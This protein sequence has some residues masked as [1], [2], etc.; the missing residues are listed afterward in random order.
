MDKAFRLAGVR[1][2]QRCVSVVVVL[3]AV[4][5][6]CFPVQAAI[7]L[8]RIFLP[9]SPV[10]WPT[11]TM[12]SSVRARRQPA[13]GFPQGEDFPVVAVVTA[14]VRPADVEIVYKSRSTDYWTTDRLV[15]DAA[16]LARATTFQAVSEP[17]TFFLRG[18]DDRTDTITLDVIERPR[19]RKIVAWYTYPEYAGL[20]NRRIE[21]GQLRGLEG[22]EV[23]IDF[24]TSGAIQSAFFVAD[25][26]EEPL[27]LTTST[28]FSKTLLLRRDGQYAIKLIDPQGFRE[29]KPERYD[30]QVTPDQP[31]EIRLLAPGRDLVA[32]PQASLKFAFEAKD[33]FGLARVAFYY[34]LQRGGKAEVLSDEITGPIPQ[35]GKESRAEFTWDLATLGLKNNVDLEYWVAAADCNPTGRGV[36]E[37][38]RFKI[39]L[40]TPTDFHNQILY[41]AKKV[42]TEAR[43]PIASRRRPT[44]SATIGSRLATL[45]DGEAHSDLWNQMVEAQETAGRANEAVKR[46]MDELKEHL[47]RNRMQDALME[48]RLVAIEDLRA[49]FTEQMVLARDPLNAA[50]PK[51]SAAAQ[52][53]RLVPTRVAALKQATDRQKLATVGFGRMLRKLYDWENLQTALV[54]TK[55]LRE[56]Q[57]EIQ[58]AVRQITPLTIGREAQDLDTQT[59]DKILTLAQK[60]KTALETETNLE[61][62]L[63]AIALKADAEGRVTVKRYMLTAY[64]YLREVRVNNTLK[65]MSAKIADNQLADVAK[66]QANVATALKVVEGTLMAA[67]KNAEGEESLAAAD[68]LKR[69]AADVEVAR[70]EPPPSPSGPDE[71]VQVNEAAV[72]KML[73]EVLPAGDDAMSQAFLALAEAQDHVRSR[74]KYLLRTMG[75]QDTPRFKQL[76]LAM[77][78]H[79]QKETSALAGDKVQPLLEKSEH[80]ARMK[81]WFAM[82]RDQMAVQED[83]SSLPQLTEATRGLQDDVIGATRELA[84]FIARAKQ[85]RGLAADHAKNG[86]VDDFNRPYLLVGDDLAKALAI[87]E[88]LDWARTVQAS[89]GRK[90]EWLK[91]QQSKLQAPEPLR[92]KIKEVTALWQEKVAQQL[93]GVKDGAAGFSGEAV[94]EPV[95]AVGLEKL[96]D[97]ALAEIGRKIGQNDIEPAARGEQDRAQEKMG[98]VVQRVKELVDARIDVVAKSAAAD[99]AKVATKPVPVETAPMPPVFQSE[100]DLAR[101]LTPQ[102]IRAT[103]EKAQHLPPEIKTRMLKELPE[104]FPERYRRL[105]GAYYRDVLE[106]RPGSKKGTEKP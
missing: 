83:C 67:G 95:T 54:N 64:G 44:G 104:Q 7:G 59:I 19:L 33:D 103:L 27:P 80:A 17:V 91:D 93:A 25:G 79:L 99:P 39:S 49:G 77:L 48:Q 62:Q 87:H 22:T 53:D 90:S 97:Q 47:Q 16:G 51:T 89:L 12:R 35:T 14:G 71:T 45:E 82:M 55:L 18:G 9:W 100:D 92:A 58:D 69:E 15:I 85:I 50:H 28:T 74:T 10:K 88:E 81:T 66:D 13:G 21:S 2:W 70:V 78:Q 23:K 38:P 61:N 98:E 41:E 8:E 32:T 86:G 40:L 101:R 105:I 42:L 106:N 52:P 46:W 56:R 73:G 5:G 20:A 96:P 34:S 29:Y 43:S 72:K 24:E 84:Q 37:S 30:I 65:V 75:P 26:L 76:K 4:L 1:R 36:T 60:Q 63:A 31:P 68:L 57:E 102:A 94:K 6:V 11:L 3:A